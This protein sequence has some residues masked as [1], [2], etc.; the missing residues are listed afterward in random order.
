MLCCRVILALAL[1]TPIFAADS[2][3]SLDTV[4]RQI[5][6]SRS[7]PD[8][9]STLCDEIGPRMAGT[10]GMQRAVDWAEQAFKDA[11][12]DAVKVEPVPMPIRWQEG[13]T[14][15][16]ALGA[17]SFT[18]RA[19]SA[20]LSPATPAGG[21]EAPVVNAGSGSQGHILRRRKEFKGKLLLIRLNEAHSF[22]GLAVEQRDAMISVREAA[23]VQAAGVLFVS[24]RP[25]GLMYRHINN[26]DGHLDPIPSAILAREDGLRLK[27]LL[28]ADQELRLRLDL[29]NQISGPFESHNVIAEMSGS[30]LPGEVVLLGA[31]LDSWDMGTGCLDNAAN[32]ALVIE[33]ARAITASKAAPRRTI[34]FALFGGEEFGL[35]GSRAYIQSRANELDNH[36]AVIVHDMGIGEVKGYSVG[37]RHDLLKNLNTALAPVKDRWKLE[38]M[39]E[40]FFGSDH[41]DFLLQGVPNLVAIQDTSNYYSPYHSEADTFDKIEMKQVRDRTALAAA[42]ALGIANLDKRFGKRYNHD[43]VDNLLKDSHLDEQMKFLEI[44]DAWQDGDRSYLESR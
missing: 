10:R 38:H 3:T 31:H 28:D 18:L 40:A 7:L 30:E 21:I 5:E 9:L 6:S 1:A 37:G 2:A 12:V 26:I 42:A 41:F 23:E 32:V 44:W 34:R 8:N 35:F 4:L 36:V 13:E 25:N 39:T 11:G 29:P 24:T 14:T 22:E 43:R 17:H 27:R 19:A 33:T 16:A 20:A 15:V